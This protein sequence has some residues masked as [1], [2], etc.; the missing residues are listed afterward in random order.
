VGLAFCNLLEKGVDWPV[1]LMRFHQVIG[2]HLRLMTRHLHRDVTQQ[3]L[4]VQR[5]HTGSKGQRGRCAV[6]GWRL[7]DLWR[8][9][10]QDL[11]IGDQPA[12]RVIGDRA[13]AGLAGRG[14]I[15][16]GQSL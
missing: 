13:F 15:A 6:R 12:G 5:A 3:P 14:S 11:L 2:N 8:G 7:S 4:N 16:I 1:F 10:S 9:V